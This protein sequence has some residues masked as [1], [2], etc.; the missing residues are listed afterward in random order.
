MSDAVSG[1][2]VNFRDDV[3]VEQYGGVVKAMSVLPGVL[4]VE[5]VES[6]PEEHAIRARVRREIEDRVL[7]VVR[8]NP[9]LSLADVLAAI[10]S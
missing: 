2:I 7:A 5:P 4:S 8:A 1:L 10:Q 9:R 3:S 6:S